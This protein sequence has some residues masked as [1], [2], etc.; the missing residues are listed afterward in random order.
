MSTLKY[1]PQYSE[2]DIQDT[3]L[4]SINILSKTKEGRSVVIK[5]LDRL[6]DNMEKENVKNNT[7]EA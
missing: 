2:K 5:I 4:Q 3:T 6:I 7:V 1:S